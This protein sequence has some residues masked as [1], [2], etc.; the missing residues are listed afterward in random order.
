MNKI[1]A[2]NLTYGVCLAASSTTEYSA[3]G[4][5]TV[6]TGEVIGPAILDFWL[7]GFGSSSGSIES[8]RD[9]EPH[10]FWDI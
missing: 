10:A 6:T 5:S 3:S 2:P 1:E 7:I 8:W 9:G 4:C